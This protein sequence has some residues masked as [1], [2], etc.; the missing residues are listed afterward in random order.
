MNSHLDT[1]VSAFDDVVR[2]SGPVDTGRVL[3]P[4]DAVGAYR[5]LLGRSPSARELESCLGSS[6]TLREFLVRLTES[7]EFDGAGGLFPPN[8][9]LM[10]EVEG[11]RFWFNTSDREMGVPMALGRYEPA[12]VALL[13]KLVR[14]GMRC[15]DVGAQTGFFTGLMATLAGPGGAVDAF[16][17]MPDNFALLERN[18]AE[19]EWHTVRAHHVAASNK[20]GALE[21]SRVSQMYVAGRVDGAPL[22]TV[23][24][25]RIDDVVS[26]PVDVVKLDIEGHEPSALAGMSRLL[27]SARPI[28]ISECNEYWLRN[29]S[30]TTSGEY[31]RA[32]ESRGYVL[33]D[34]RHL[35]TPM[36]AS[37]VHLDI[38]DTMDVVAV[39]RGR[40]L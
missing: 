39:P 19:N 33:Y 12:S 2:T 15:I 40:T 14:P 38:L 37:S 32:L 30:G 11:F 36:P 16:E 17:P 7:P 6:L 3:N 9:R 28:I 4:I 20:P 35:T 10:A 8:R 13:K 23:P 1:L 22:V 27:T 24:T 5:L 21:M 29:C 18:V 34:A 25:V 26:T 31:C